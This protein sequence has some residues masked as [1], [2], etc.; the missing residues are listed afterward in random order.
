MKLSTDLKIF[1]KII[2]YSFKKPELLIRALTHSSFSSVNR[3]DNQRLEFL[4]DRVLGLVIAQA[5]LETDPSASEGTLAPRFNA[6]VRKEAC[7]DIAL[8][9]KLGDV[10]KL[11]NSEMISGGRKKQAILGDSMEAL[12]AAVYLDGGFEAAKTFINNLWKEKIAEVEV[13]ARDSK[14]ALQE[15]V[16]GLGHNPPKYSVIEKSGPDHA[17][18]FKVCVSI[19]SGEEG[20]A[21]ASSKRKAEQAAAKELFDRIR[22]GK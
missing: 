13:D 12:I 15:F 10:L 22:I 8:E 21:I 11:G 7:A 2:N 19:S 18:Q 6:M 3:S 9:I 5:L 4:G 1:S 16:Q 20:H 17:P 14:T